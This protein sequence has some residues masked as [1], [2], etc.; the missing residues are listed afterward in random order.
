MERNGAMRIR[1]RVRERETKGVVLKF[2]HKVEQEEVV[3]VFRVLGSGVIEIRALV[4]SC[5]RG[6][7]EQSGG[8]R[9]PVDLSVCE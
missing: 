2:D 5:H 7:R 3:Q 6:P 9:D 1:M 4:T 8:Q